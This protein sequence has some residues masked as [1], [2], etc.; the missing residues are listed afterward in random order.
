M[1]EIVQHRLRPF[2]QRDL[3]HEH[4][5]ALH[6]VLAQGRGSRATVPAQWMSLCWP[7]RGSVWLQAEGLEWCMQAG[8]YQ[9]WGQGVLQCRTTEANG[10]LLIAG[11]RQAWPEALHRRHAEAL[12]LPWQ[13]RIDRELAH[14]LLAAARIDES[15]S[16]LTMRDAGIAVLENLLQ[17][18]TD[19]HA[20]L[21]RCSGR[22]CH[23]RQQ[24][25]SRLLRV[26][27]AIA[28]D[29]GR[30]QDLDQLAALANYSPC[31]LLRMHRR[32]F[33]QTPFEYASRLRDRQALELI[34]DTDLSILDISLRMGFENQSAF[35]RA[36]KGS[37]GATPTE[38]R[39]HGHAATPRAA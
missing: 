35:C 14:S 39:R 13:E 28:C 29:P 18:Q 27:H 34:R 17:R 1:T 32:V 36:F 6:V 16:P 26:R 5:R 24:T 9:L 11:A 25:L 15:A 2:G 21:E 12:A 33:G 8:R 4:P 3:H 38:L 37:F 23:L 31:H 22:T 30:R 20:L 7:I 19:L 10:W